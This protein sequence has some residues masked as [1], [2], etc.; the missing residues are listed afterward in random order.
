MIPERDK[1]G[2]FIKSNTPNRER[3][4]NI[5]LTDS[6]YQLIR[7]AKKKGLSPREVVLQ[8]AQRMLNENKQ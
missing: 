8:E 4:F 3:F 7:A 1:Q 6:E 2:R 5:R